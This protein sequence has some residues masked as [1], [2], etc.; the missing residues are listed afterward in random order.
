M[1]GERIAS[2]S[3][4]AA[5][6][7]RMPDSSAWF[8]RGP[9][10]RACDTVAKGNRTFFRTWLRIMSPAVFIAER[11]QELADC[12]DLGVFDFGQRL[13]VHGVSGRSPTGKR[14]VDRRSNTLR[15]IQ[16]QRLVPTHPCLK[17]ARLFKRSRRERATK[18]RT[19]PGWHLTPRIGVTFN[20]RLELLMAAR[21]QAGHTDYR[22]FRS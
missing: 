15:R 17:S 13:R 21:T 1:S 14:I 6:F 9:H 3:G 16:P 10:S 18:A 11:D 12:F 19:Q 5:G 7:S 20:V 4:P 22:F 2:G 8:G